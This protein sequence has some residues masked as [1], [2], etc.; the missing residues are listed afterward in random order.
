M[1]ILVV[2]GCYLL[3]DAHIKSFV[4]FVAVESERRLAVVV[5]SCVDCVHMLRVY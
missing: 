3:S 5:L 2:N 1:L 4:S